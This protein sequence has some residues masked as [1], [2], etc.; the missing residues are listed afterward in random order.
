MRY[1]L[2]IV[3]SVGLLF[4]CTKKVSKTDEKWTKDSLAFAKVRNYIADPAN[5]TTISWIDTVYKELD[6]VT[7]GKM[8]EVSWAFENSG[9]KPLVIANVMTSCKC[10]VVDKPKKQLLPG[11]KGIIKAKFDTKGLQGWQRKDVYVLVNNKSNLIQTLSFAVHVM[12]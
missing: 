3:L 1:L 6:T 5:G 7:A 11:E 9:G 2:H 4:A 10:T 8:V 12:K